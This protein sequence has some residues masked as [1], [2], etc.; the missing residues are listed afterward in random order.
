MWQVPA[1]R[2]SRATALRA[3][4]HSM[5]VSRNLST[6]TVKPRPTHSSLM[7]LDGLSPSSPKGTLSKDMLTAYKMLT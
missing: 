6:T 3:P 4:P 1:P 7:L 5:G 2:R